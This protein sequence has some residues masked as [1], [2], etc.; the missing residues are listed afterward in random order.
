MRRLL[1]LM[2]VAASV[3]CVGDRQPPAAND[4]PDPGESPIPDLGTGTSAAALRPLSGG[5]L[6]VTRDGDHAVVSDPDRDRVLIVNL[7]SGATTATIPLKAGDEPGRAAED[8]DGRVHVALRGGGDLLTVAVDQGVVLARRQACGGPRGVAFDPATSRVH[9]ACVTGELVSFDAAPPEAPTDGTEIDPTQ[10]FAVR[11]LRLGPDLR[12]VV[13][14]G[15]QLL[16]SRF[17]KADV[18]VLD[19][20]GVEVH[21][22][23]PPSYLDPATGNGF[24]PS[25]AWRMFAT[26]GGGAILAHQR[27]STREID[28][29]GSAPVGSY[30]PPAGPS[31]GCG[32]GL[33]TAGLT[34]YASDGTRTSAW[35]GGMLGGL[36]LPVD[37][38]NSQHGDLIAVVGA[39]GTVLEGP[40]A[41]VMT[42][43]GCNSPLP[44]TTYPVEDEPVA[45]AYRDDDTLVV[46]TRDPLGLRLYHGGSLGRTI[47]LEGEPLR[48]PG[49]ARFH[50]IGAEPKVQLACASC[51]P[52][53]RED[54][55]AWN[56]FPFG[57]RRTQSL[58]GSVLDTAPFHW[59]GDFAALDALLSEVLVHRMA[60][61]ALTGEEK[62]AFERFLGAIPRLPAGPSAGAAGLAAF[63]K[64]KCDACHKGPKLTNNASADVGTG[65]TFQVPSLVGVRYRAPF[66]HDGCAGT[67]TDRFGA[68]GGGTAHGHPDALSAAEL[69]ALVAYLDSL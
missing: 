25:V 56:F 39:T 63:E 9:V 37:A 52:E 32:D 18:L 61:E 68:C 6:L 42:V 21:R 5:T 8:A 35:N 30:S 22:E 10:D 41:D 17:T 64:A 7:A 59:D 53:G 1:P 44:A 23:R 31:G 54:G 46:Q 27:S 43:D 29:D 65:G 16:V 19:A 40:T 14:S 50:G 58:A 57:P 11:R 3:A 47:T 15:D 49:Y 20:Q 51:H 4:D 34:A 24:A 55:H 2:F 28:V 26:P 62:A 45:V 38:A 60:Q 13:V 12:D 48:D 36:A 69:D 33:V 66:M 67:L